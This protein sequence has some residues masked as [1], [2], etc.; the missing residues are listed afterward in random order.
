[1]RIFLDVLIES[2][3]DLNSTD[4]DGLSVMHFAAL[5]R[6]TKNITSILG[7]KIKFKCYNF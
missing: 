4:K 7:G 5:N 2:G 3:A 1:M 6:K